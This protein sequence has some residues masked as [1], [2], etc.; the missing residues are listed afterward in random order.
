MDWIIFI[1]GDPPVAPR[2]TLKG[3]SWRD[4]LE[5]AYSAAEPGDV[6]HVVNP[7]RELQPPFRREDIEALVEAD[8]ERAA[9][10]VLRRMHPDIPRGET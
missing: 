2:L 7:A 6:V 5:R 1:G 8:I 10:K 3:A 4:C 9:P